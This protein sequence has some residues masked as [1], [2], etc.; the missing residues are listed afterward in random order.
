MGRLEGAKDWAWP[1][2]VAAVF[3]LQA[4]LTLSHEPW[5]DEWQALLIA[6]RPLS[7]L[8]EHLSY[9]GHPPLWYLIL[10]VV[11]Q[12][13]GHNLALPMTALI[14]GLA[15]QALILARAPFTMP[16]R[17][18]LAL[19]EP[20]LFEFNTI[21]RSF[22]LGAFLVVLAMVL[23]RHRTVWIAV[24][25]LPMADFLFGAVS[26]VFV[27]LLLSERR[28]DWAGLAGWLVVSIIAAWSVIPAPDFE[29]T[30]YSGS[31]VT[32]G[33]L[34][35]LTKLSSLAVP[36]HW[37][38]DGPHWN[39]GL[40]GNL[41]VLG[42]IAFLGLIVW[43]LR[44]RPFELALLLGF[45]A[46][47]WA[48]SVFVYSLYPR[49]LM[50]IGLLFVALVWRQGES[51]KPFEIWL[52]V[53]AICGVATA[54]INIAIPFDN[55]RIA[56]AK[57]REIGGYWIATNDFV[58]VP[59][60]AITGEAIEGLDRHCRSTFI[61]WDKALLGSGPIERKI[62]N[63]RPGSFNLMSFRK[64]NLPNAKLLAHIP[65]GFDGNQLFLYRIERG[66]PISPAGPCLPAHAGR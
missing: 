64:V 33:T 37:G 21:S 51:E 14:L 29:S 34:M 41:E 17:L 4:C 43:T 10:K 48:M 19:S 38:G 24:A 42:W 52:G 7:E 66:P 45:I 5:L 61:R 2:A 28:F 50:L 46:L 63:M 26:G 55:G 39:A 35:W 56:A 6:E 23:W 60:S 31:D 25:L 32:L 18:M 12:F 16:V 47:T 22:T 58:S 62:L 3:A 40:P 20:I 57:I 15:T 9:E 11:G 30:L 53:A 8:L 36:F 1:A 49:H 54:A 65:G 59:V 27:L 44:K 13:V